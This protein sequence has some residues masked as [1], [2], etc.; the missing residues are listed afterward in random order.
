LL[1]AGTA[2]AVKVGGTLYVRTPNTRVMASTAPTADAVLVLQPGEEVVWQ[3]ADSK[4]KRWHKVSAKGKTGYVFQS[5]LSPKK[6]TGEV[7][8]R[9]GAATTDTAAFASSGAAT[10]ALGDGAVDY[11]KKKQAGE[12]VNQLLTLEA[13]AKKVTPAEVAKRSKQTG[14]VAATGGTP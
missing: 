7:V 14:V 12:A 11:G 1:V 3:G 13:L 9:A 4:N 8:A 10:K 6:P 5:N 2:A